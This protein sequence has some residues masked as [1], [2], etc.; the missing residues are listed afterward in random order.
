MVRHEDTIRRHEDTVRT[1]VTTARTTIFAAV[2]FDPGHADI[3]SADQPLL[4]R[5]AALLVQNPNMRLRV[6]GYANDRGSDAKARQLG[7]DRALAVRTYLIAHGVDSAHVSVVSN[8]DARL[9]CRSADSSC[10][11]RNARDEFSIIAGG[12]EITPDR[13]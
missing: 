13:D 1:V 4:D 11:S 3:R 10:Q 7:L 9:L 12:A 2:H 8:G 5:K 6:F